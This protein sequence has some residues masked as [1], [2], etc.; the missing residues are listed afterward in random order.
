MVNELF[1]RL[2]FSLSKI[3]RIHIRPRWS[4]S[5]HLASPKNL[6]GRRV[7]RGLDAKDCQRSSQPTP[8]V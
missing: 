7:L 6:Q 3:L 4:V 2:S 8:Y 5:N 1:H